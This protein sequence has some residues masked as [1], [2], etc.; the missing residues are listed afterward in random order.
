MRV[1]SALA[2]LASK[3]RVTRVLLTLA[4][5]ALFTLATDPAAANRVICQDPRKLQPCKA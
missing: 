5:V 3:P 4:L 1:S 2:T